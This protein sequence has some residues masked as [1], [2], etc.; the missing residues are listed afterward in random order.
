[1]A[2]KESAEVILRAGYYE[3]AQPIEF[4]PEDSGTAESPVIWRAAEGEEVRLGGGR[5]VTGWRKISEPSVREKLDPAVRDLVWEIDLRAEGISDFGDMSGGFAKPSSTGL[6]LFIDDIPGHVSRYPNAGF[7]PIEEVTGPTKVD[8]RGTIGTKE[9]TFR[10]ADPRIFRWTGE[11]DPRAL[12]FWF[13][14][15][16]EQHQKIVSIEPGTGT[17]RLAEPWHDMGYRKGQYFYAY[18]LLSEIDQPGEWMLDRNSGR[19]YLLPPT[20]TPGRTV[21][22]M[23]PAIVV[24]KN[25]S[26]VTL[27]GFIFE[28]ARGDAVIM[29]D[30]SFCEITKCTLRNC[31]KWAVSIEGGKACQV[32]DSTI[33]EMGDGGVA[34]TGGD[35][36]TLAPAN[37]AV[38]RCHIYR[39]GRWSRT[40]QPGIRLAGVGNLATNNL[41][42]DA[43]HQAIHLEGNDH[44]I[45]YNEIHNV[46]EET[47]DAGAIYGWNDWA[48]R[49]NVIRYNYLHHIYGLNGK[50]ANG[51]YLD[52]AFSSAEI[53]CNIF[54]T[55]TRPIMLGGGRDHVVTENLFV[56]CAPAI[57]IDA[58]GLNWRA[59]GFD[60]LK[61]KLETMP[62]QRPPWSE[63]WPQLLS[64]LA[65]EPMAPKGITV[66]R[67]IAVDSEWNGIE[68]KARP[69]VSLADNLFDASC[70][71][72]LPGPGMPRVDMKNPAVQK[73]GF[74]ELPYDVIGLPRAADH[75][76]REQA[77]NPAARPPKRQ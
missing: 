19:L 18:N 6:E 25:A 63:R 29:R 34:L 44:H 56:D 9:G 73:I 21:V 55:M 35:R 38:L 8:I 66:T 17:I 64:L 45:E 47:N 52:D 32:T 12:G 68:E 20:E 1:M 31:G 41:I 77:W 24:L 3:L 50:G 57:H 51:V 11:K 26:H 33:S 59:F 62:Y 71:V 58:R 60:E 23:L 69:Y 14:D 7:I 48:A 22:S 65:E 42:H 28:N 40:Y 76:V 4:G 15:W 70:D 10:V 67:N 72:L 37:H 54:Q 43:P 36:R 5:L 13:W 49:G 75:P 61:M 39:Y 74:P 16:A 46:C 53:R 30:S 2:R 27:R